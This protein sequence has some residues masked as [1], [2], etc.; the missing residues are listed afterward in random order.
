MIARANL[1][2][3]SVGLELGCSG[4]DELRQQSIIGIV[5]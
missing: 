4:H 2:Y 5:N 1:W 3:F